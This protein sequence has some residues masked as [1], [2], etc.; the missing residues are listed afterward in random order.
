MVTRRLSHGS[1]AEQLVLTTDSQFGRSSPPTRSS[2]GFFE[3]F[4]GL[5]G[6]R[7][8][9]RP[10]G[11]NSKVG[12]YVR[13]GDHPGRTNERELRSAQIPAGRTYDG[14]KPGGNHAGAV[15]EF[16]STQQG[17]SA[18]FMAK[19]RALAIGVAQVMSLRVSTSSGLTT[20]LGRS[21]CTLRESSL[22]EKALP[23][24][25]IRRACTYRLLFPVA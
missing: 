8:Y 14:G 20:G 16:V 24:A 21:G 18:E 5:R 17:D 23:S 10:P 25:Y 2:T 11:Q 12:G 4:D 1:L 15:A 7:A 19:A 13:I 9:H 22:L 6:L 3:P